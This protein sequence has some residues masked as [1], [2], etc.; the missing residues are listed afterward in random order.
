MARGS[1]VPPPLAVQ[2]FTH[3]RKKTREKPE[4]LKQLPP[5]FL[6]SL[7]VTN[8][9]TCKSR[10]IHKTIDF[11]FFFLFQ[12]CSRPS[13][14]FS[15]MFHSFFWICFTVDL[16]L[17]FVFFSSVQ[18]AGGNEEERS[19]EG[20]RSWK[21][22]AGRYGTVGTAM[23]GLL[24]EALIRSWR[25]GR[26]AMKEIDCCCGGV[27]SGGCWS[28]MGSS[29]GVVWWGWNHREKGIDRR[30]MTG[31]GK[32]NSGLFMVKGGEIS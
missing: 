20:C 24:L 23:F 32:N 7:A 25:A 12:I 2:G 9:V 10:K 4:D 6:S 18:V 1:H 22:E 28:V 17:L 13:F 11:N 15:N 21:K 31:R 5:F 26:L 19:R 27:C 14:L 8:T 16:F 30:G 29:S 3:P